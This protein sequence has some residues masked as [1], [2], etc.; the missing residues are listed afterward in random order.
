MTW[1][2]AAAGV[3][4]VVIATPDA[5]VAPVAEAIAPVAVHRGRRTSRARSGSTSWRPTPGGRRCTRWSRCPTR[6]SG[7]ARLASA[8]SPSR[9]PATRWSDRSA[10][11]WAGGWSGRRRRPGRLPRRRHHRRQ[12]RGRPAGPGGA[13]GRRRPASRST[14]SPGWYG[15]PSTTPWLS[16]RAAL[17]GPAARGDWETIA[18]HRAV[19][20][21]WP[22]KGR[23]RRRTTPRWPWPAGSSTDPR[24]PRCPSRSPDAVQ[25]RQ[26]ELPPRRH[27]R[28][29]I[30]RCRHRPE[31]LARRHRTVAEFGRRLDAARR[32]GLTVGL[33]PTMGRSTP[34]IAPWSSGPPPSATWWPSPS[35]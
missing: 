29:W 6:R 35:S 33:V 15:P 7:A 34:A 12:P 17:T 20:P 18:R 26:H 8:G 24:R 19:L 16:G 2:A 3:D 11:P 5:A 1:A 25:G 28:R 13:G 4:L 9:W 30:G 32:P 21:P 27:R 23:A 14:P 10:S 31:R 22:T